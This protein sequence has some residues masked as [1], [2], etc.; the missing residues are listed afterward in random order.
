LLRGQLKKHAP[1]PDRSR[2]CSNRA[3]DGSLEVSIGYLGKNSAG[4]HQYLVVWAESR[5]AADVPRI[6][7]GYT[8][9][10]VKIVAD[11]RGFATW[12]GGDGLISTWRVDDKLYLFAAKSLHVMKL[13]VASN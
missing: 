8:T 10:F 3:S 1:A 5:K 13:P 6:L 7:Y 12:P 2:S 4:K 9:D 11:R